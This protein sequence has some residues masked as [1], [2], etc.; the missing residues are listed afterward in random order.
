[1][2]SS[3]DETTPQCSPSDYSD[4][5]HKNNVMNDNVITIDS[6]NFKALKE[7]KADETKKVC[8]DKVIEAVKNG[9]HNERYSAEHADMQMAHECANGIEMTAASSC[10]TSSSSHTNGYDTATDVRTSVANAECSNERRHDTEDAKSDGVV[11]TKSDTALSE[12]NSNCRMEANASNADDHHID[13]IELDDDSNSCIEAPP[14]KKMKCDQQ[15]GS[16]QD[17]QESPIP[18]DPQT[19]SSHKRP[20][21]TSSEALL[22]KLEAYVKEAIESAINIQVQREPLSVRKLILEKQL[23]LPNTISFPPSQAVD[24]LIE[25]DPDAPLSKVITRLFGEERP[26]LTEAEKRD[27]HL[28]KMSHPAPHMTKLLMDIGQD[29]VQESTYSDIVHAKNLP[30][31]PKNMETYKQV[32]Q[33]LKPVWEALRKK[34]EPYKLKQYTC[35]LCCF[36]TESRIVLALHRQTPHFDGRKHQCALC[37]EYFTNENMIVQ[38]YAKQHELVAGKEEAIPKNPCPCCDEDFMYKGQRD[39]HLKTCRRD[40]NRVR[41]IMAPKAPHDVSAINQ[42]LW[43]KPPVDPAI[44][45]QQ[46]VAQRQ[47]AEKQQRAQ[48][49]QQQ[50]QQQQRRSQTVNNNPALLAAQQ[51][52]AVYLL[53]QQRLRAAQAQAAAITQQ[54]VKMSNIMNNPSL[55]AAVQQQLQRAAAAGIR[56]PGITPLFGVRL[57]TNSVRSSLL[58]SGSTL[59]NRLKTPSQVPSQRN[60]AT[61]SA[62]ASSSHNSGNMCEICDQNVQDKDRYLT[63]LQLFHKQMRGKSSVDMQQGAPLACSRCRDRFWTYEGLERHL[64]MAHGLVTSDLLTKAQK[65]EDGGRCKL[66]GKQ[67]AFNMLQHLVTDHQVKLCSAEIM[68]SCDVCAFKCSSYNKLEVHLNT[69][70]PKNP[71]QSTSISGNVAVSSAAGARENDSDDEV[72]VLSDESNNNRLNASSSCGSFSISTSLRNILPVPNLMSTS[73]VTKTN[74]NTNRKDSRTQSVKRYRQLLLPLKATT[75]NSQLIKPNALQHRY[76]CTKCSVSFETIVDVIEHWQQSHLTPMR[77]V[78][79][80]IDLCQVH[81]TE[82]QERHKLNVN[83]QMPERLD[84]DKEADMITL[85]DD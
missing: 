53:Q 72:I 12:A 76:N 68:Y 54:Q 30:E 25:H 61:N 65:K 85:D 3:S 17:E 50:Q 29:L 8:G 60:I 6:D 83:L 4:E 58:P 35:Q 59:G 81:L 45:Q 42:W 75:N 74:V 41:L 66:C 2:V 24:L 7:S 63:H 80:K 82:F 19:E 67:Y 21:L 62:V 14:A 38:H 77:V 23:V 47:Q 5:A 70:H 78:L 31:T 1:M 84:A 26:K 34:N 13:C 64:V 15:N 49:A 16:N 44:L 46:Q 28:L 55:L 32:A 43:E 52:Q 40:L 39:Q 56:T 9:L 69:V 20:E 22:N 11:E 37:P 10:S 33:Q 48:L 18:D 71:N 51:Q 79:C 73:T 27:R 36:K 57:P